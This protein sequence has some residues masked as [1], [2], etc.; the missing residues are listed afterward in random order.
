MRHAKL[1]SHETEWYSVFGKSNA[2]LCSRRENRQ[3]HWWVWNWP[4]LQC[5]SF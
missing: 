3:A 5:I 4:D 2:A 1:C